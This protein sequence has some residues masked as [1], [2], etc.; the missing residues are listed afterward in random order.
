MTGNARKREVRKQTWAVEYRRDATGD[1]RGEY[2]RSY[3][4][5]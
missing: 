1:D 4:Q 2:C 5:A 3:S